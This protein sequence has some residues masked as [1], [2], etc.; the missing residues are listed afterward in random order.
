M[1]VAGAINA[2]THEI[3][4]LDARQQTC[5]ILAVRCKNEKY[6]ENIG[7]VLLRKYRGTDSLAGFSRGGMRDIKA[8]GGEAVIKTD[9]VRTNL[10]K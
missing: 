5:I 6:Y 10:V 3:E 7:K 9:H 2:T 4:R 1:K 8:L